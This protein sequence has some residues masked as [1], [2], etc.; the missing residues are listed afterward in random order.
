MYEVERKATAVSTL[1][2]IS[3]LSMTSSL[4]RP[5]FISAIVVFVIVTLLVITRRINTDQS[6]LHGIPEYSHGEDVD[7]VNALQVDSSLTKVLPP[8]RRNNIAVASV[9]GY[10]F[11]V[12]MALVWTLERAFTAD[13]PGTVRVFADPFPLGFP[14]VIDRLGL[15]S[16]PLLK[17]D[18]LI[19]ELIAPADNNQID[20]VILGTC[21]IE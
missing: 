20:M 18:E 6:Q 10:H 12:Y 9:F 19:P 11:D 14:V 8:R 17:P 2:A 3:R 16:G 13:E 1:S 21:E 7:S 5:L 15:Y 4:R